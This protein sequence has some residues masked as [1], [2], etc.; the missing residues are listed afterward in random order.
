[1]KFNNKSDASSVG[2]SVG[3]HHHR[4]IIPLPRKKERDDEGKIILAKPTSFVV[5]YVVLRVCCICVFGTVYIFLN[6]DV[7]QATQALPQGRPQW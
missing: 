7:V 3:I 5:L 6:F 1:M 2:Q 4:I